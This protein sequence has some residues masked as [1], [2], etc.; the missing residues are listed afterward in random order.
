MQSLHQTLKAHHSKFHL[1][2]E[3]V[4]DRKPRWQSRKASIANICIP[5]DAMWLP[6]TTVNQTN[7]ELIGSRD[8]EIGYCHLT[9]WQAKCENDLSNSLR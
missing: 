1:T 8:G 6:C 9:F 5:W 7:A 3:I 4:I 2:K